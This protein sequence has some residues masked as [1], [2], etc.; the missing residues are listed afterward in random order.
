M[1]KS[2]PDGSKYKGEWKDGKYDGQGILKHPDDGG[3]YEGEW[4][5][6]KKCG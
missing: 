1:K 5:D 3:E 2:Y 6:G 4:K